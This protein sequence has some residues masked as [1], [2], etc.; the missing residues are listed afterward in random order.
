M[1][2]S[3]DLNVE[4]SVAPGR[5]H[6]RITLSG[7]ID[8]RS[9]GRFTVAGWEQT[10]GAGVAAVLIDARA[11]RNVGSTVDNLKY[12]RSVCRG[13][14]SDPAFRATRQVVLVSP[15]DRSHDFVVRRFRELGQNITLTRDESRALHLIEEM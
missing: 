10:L 8:A 5:T 7:R 11:A 9:V 1:N 15:G 14:G 6:L 3:N 4:F 2:D 12:A 13:I